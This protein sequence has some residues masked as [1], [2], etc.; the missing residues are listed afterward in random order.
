MEGAWITRVTSEGIHPNMDD[1][2]SNHLKTKLMLR[3]ENLPFSL[4]NLALQKKH[5]IVLFGFFILHFGHI[6]SV[7]PP[8]LFSIIL[9]SRIGPSGLRFCEHYQKGKH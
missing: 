9:F 2:I 8:S 1:D 5:L 7:S 6:N 4:D 3:P